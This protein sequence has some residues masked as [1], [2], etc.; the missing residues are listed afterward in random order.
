MLILR[1]LFYVLFQRTEI[2]QQN[3]PPRPS[4]RQ[5]SAA[6]SRPPT[7]ND[8][9]SPPMGPRVPA[10][11]SSVLPDLIQQQNPPPHSSAPPS[12][13]GFAMVERGAEL[14]PPSAQ[15]NEVLY[16]YIFIYNR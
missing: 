7:V 16:I 8:V 15:H 9:G 13:G 14:V 3:P 10:H 6:S 2:D 11:G 4:A 1:S 12:K 5:P